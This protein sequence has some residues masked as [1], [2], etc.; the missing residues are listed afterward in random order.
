MIDIQKIVLHCSDS[1][2][3]RGDTAETIHRWHRQRGWDGIGYHYV[4]LENGEVQAGRPEDWQGA[5]VAGHNSNS[6]GIC[7]IGQGDY[8][9][10]QLDAAVGLIA[11][12]R[13]RHPGAS[14]LGHYELDAKACPRLDMDEIRERVSAWGDV[15]W[16]NAGKE[17]E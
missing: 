2:Q 14:L 1:P 16:Y 10:E 6:V 13:A 11:E 5:H 7:L 12:I 9:K 17:V 15:M 3:G 4:V 8:P